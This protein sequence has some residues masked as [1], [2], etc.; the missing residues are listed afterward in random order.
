ML[1]YSVGLSSKINGEAGLVSLSASQTTDT[2]FH[3]AAVENQTTAN[4]GSSVSYEPGLVILV[5]LKHV[6]TSLYN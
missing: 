6:K 5:L 2:V 3:A 4:F 1:K